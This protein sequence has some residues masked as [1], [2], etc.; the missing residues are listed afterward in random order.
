MVFTHVLQHPPLFFFFLH[1]ATE[2]RNCYIFPLGHA[3]PLP[4]APACASTLQSNPS[5]AAAQGS[6]PRAWSCRCYEPLFSSDYALCDNGAVQGIQMR[7]HPS[8]QIAQVLPLFS[9]NEPETPLF[10]L[11][12]LI[13]SRSLSDSFVSK[14]HDMEEMVGLG[15]KLSSCPY[16]AS[17]SIFNPTITTLNP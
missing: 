3:C 16:Y 4:P 1:A 9:E 17:R 7:V 15:T 2:K 8:P 11:K 12:P 6:T 5:V 10:I 14:P 13:L